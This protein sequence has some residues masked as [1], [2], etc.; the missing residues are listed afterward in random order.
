MKIIPFLNK[1]A[2]LY[3]DIESSQKVIELF[4]RHS[5]A[6]IDDKGNF[7]TPF[8]KQ[9]IEDLGY[10]A[11][12]IV[13]KGI[14]NFADWSNVMVKDLGEGIKDHLQDIYDRLKN[15]R[16]DLFPL[17]I[18][19]DDKSP[20]TDK[21]NK[22]IYNERDLDDLGYI[23][24]YHFERGIRY[25]PDW[26][27]E[28]I[29]SVGEK[30]IPYLSGIYVGEKNFFN[31]IEDNDKSQEQNELNNSVKHP[32]KEVI[33]GKQKIINNNL[34]KVTFMNSKNLFKL[35]LAIAFLACLIKMPFWYYQLIRT[36]G[37]AGFIYFA[38]L[39]YKDH[40][41]YIPQF[42]IIGAIIINPFYKIP[43]EKKDLQYID[44]IFSVLL[45][46]NVFIDKKR[47]GSFDKIKCLLKNKKFIWLTSVLIVLIVIIS[48][49]IAYN[50]TYIFRNPNLKTITEIWD[51]KLGTILEDV[52]FKKGIPESA[53]TSNSRINWYYKTNWDDYNRI[54]FHN[55]HVTAVIITGDNQPILCGQNFI[56]QNSQF[57][58][59]Y[60]GK[61]SDVSTSSN[62]LKK[63]F[64]YDN[65]NILFYLEKD[66]V[67]GSGIYDP[68]YGTYK[69]K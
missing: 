51:I 62:G 42:F 58:I 4:G 17:E 16:K 39:D 67:F 60:L 14:R 66:R 28:M 59:D 48:S 18:K 46:A 49:L 63:I 30:I 33:E 50:K 3:S 47:V 19:N 25:F 57:I 21:I 56:G 53:D 44:L 34:F 13:E 64:S 36:L 20:I 43:F 24:G 52:K 7:V 8:S 38:Y 41:K 9:D 11:G 35:L 10:I 31:K 55:E 6:L 5:K 54:V 32:N 69:Y 12:N 2:L 15:E 23:G 29:N 26:S 1:S 68:H 22:E 65:Y 37:V 27:N 40:I 45:L 61:P